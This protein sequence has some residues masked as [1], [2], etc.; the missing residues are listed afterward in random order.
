MDVEVTRYSVWYTLVVLGNLLLFSCI[1]LFTVYIWFIVSSPNSRKGFFIVSANIVHLCLMVQV[2]FF[3]TIIPDN[4]IL[5][6]FSN[7]CCIVCKCHSLGQL[8]FST[9]EWALHYFLPSLLWAVSSKP[10]LCSLRKC[11]FS[12][13]EEYNQILWKYVSL[14]FQ[15]I[16]QFCSWQFYFLKDCG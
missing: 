3:F 13:H 1:V 7:V 4:Q 6:T 12:L 5:V 8:L 2:C 9:E 15:L 11:F 16:F 10:F 14:C